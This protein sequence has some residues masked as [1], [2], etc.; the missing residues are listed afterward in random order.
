MR[1]RKRGKH[2]Q[3][4]LWSR[5]WRG[6]WRTMWPRPRRPQSAH[7]GGLR[8]PRQVTRD[9]SPGAGPAVS[10]FVRP[11]HLRRRRSRRSRGISISANARALAMLRS[12]LPT[13]PLVPEVFARTSCRRGA[14]SSSTPCRSADRTGGRTVLRSHGAPGA[15]QRGFATHGCS[16]P[17]PPTE[18]ASTYGSNSGARRLGDPFCVILTV[19]PPRCHSAGV[20]GGAGSGQP[21]ARSAGRNR[22]SPR[23]PRECVLPQMGARACPVGAPGRHV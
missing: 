15:W 14:A 21:E 2:S 7:G 17:H 13:R 20:P 10:H 22:P 6:A 3:P 12:G 1:G 8:R 4:N 9:P 23:H 18:G 11:W 16:A 5:G 19:L